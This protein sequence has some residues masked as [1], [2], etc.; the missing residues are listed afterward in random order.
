[1]YLILCYII[2]YSALIQGNG[3]INADLYS[4]NGN[5]IDFIKIILLFGL[6]KTVCLDGLIVKV[7]QELN[8]IN[9]S[10]YEVA[11]FVSSGFNPLEPK[12]TITK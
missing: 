2:L 12:A 4:S 8:F 7:G 1:M 10:D 9:C 3:L 6:R 5:A 11:Q